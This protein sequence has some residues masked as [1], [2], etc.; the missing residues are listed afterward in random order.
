MKELQIGKPLLVLLYVLG[1]LLTIEWLGPISEL[2][3]TGHISLFYGFVGMSLLFGMLRIP[4]WISAPIKMSYIYFS[5]QYVFY[6]KDFLSKEAMQT[7]AADFGQSISFISNGEWM[8][9]S[10][11]FRT[12]LFFVLLWMITYLLRFWLEYRKSLFLFFGMT[13]IFLSVVDTFTDFDASYAILRVMILGL[14]LLGLLYPLKLSS[15]N[16]TQLPLSNYFKVVAP[17]GGV[18]VLIAIV[19]ILV[20][21]KEPAWPD[22]VPYIRSAAG[23][24]DTGSGSGVSKVGYDE[25]DTSLGG[26]FQQDDTLVFEAYVDSRQ[27]WRMETKDMYTTKGWEKYA[28]EDSLSE[29]GNF[30]GIMG[31]Q[32]LL[33]PRERSDIDLYQ[34]LPVLPYPY[35]FQ[36]LQ[37]TEGYFYRLDE[38]TGKLELGTDELLDFTYRTEFIEPEYSLKELRSTDMNELT[39]ME[40]EMRQYLSLPNE[41]PE[42]VGELAQ[43]LTAEA[44]SVYEKAQAI[45]RYFGRSG[46]VYS[47]E[48]VAIPKEDEDYVDQFLF[49]TKRG[50]CDN[51]STSMVVM[52]RSVGI[53]A[54]WVKGFAPGEQKID[55]D[56]E[57]YYKVTNN[58]AHSWVEAYMPGIGWM[59]FEPTIGFSGAANV[60]Y[61]V[62]VAEDDVKEQEMIKRPEEEKKKK[63]QE[64][65][66]KRKKAESSWLLTIIPEWLRSWVAISI[67]IGTGLVAILITL[68]FTRKKWIP[69]AGVRRSRKKPLGWQSFADEYEMLLKQFKRIGIEKPPGMTLSD[70][71][72]RVNR[73][74]GDDRMGILTSVYEAGLYGRRENEQ[75]WAE[76]REI[77]EDLIIETT[78]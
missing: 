8:E 17:L 23:F 29:E 38:D 4:A 55:S 50:Y 68:F 10:Y 27:Y 78:G 11:L 66:A 58:Q 62:E 57:K 60:N 21:I 63:E 76:L 24:G 15:K 51:F 12:I 73:L 47:R 54:R 30:S 61:D 6:E 44:T 22:P 35:G 70:Y 5:I 32:V 75:N 3:S 36:E 48:D 56:R 41:V 64:Q 67:I 59:P 28:S 20:P 52:L 18:L 49:E 16:N 72:K 65:A 39:A 13:V 42:R 1:F 69:R 31:G 2:T 25:D 71:A 40:Y 43:D 74:R 19:A 37:T 34:P 14:L 26:A 53:P 33:P 46:F 77:W 45:E 7:T 9:I